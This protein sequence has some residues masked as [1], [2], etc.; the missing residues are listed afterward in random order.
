MVFNDP[1]IRFSSTS[2]SH[3][4]LVAILVNL[5]CLCFEIYLDFSPYNIDASF[6]ACGFPNSL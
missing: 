6:D 4:R 5:K 1:K 3:K 2:A